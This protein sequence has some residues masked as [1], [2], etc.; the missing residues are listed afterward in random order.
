MSRRILL[1][2][3]G[4][5]PVGTGREVLLASR[6]LL[7]VGDDLHVAAITQPG[8]VATE[9][10]AGGGTLHALSHR[11][12][13]D[14]ASIAALAQTIRRVRPRLVVSWGWSAWWVTGAA[15]AVQ[16]GRRA[17]RWLGSVGRPTTPATPIA[18]WAARRLMR[19][20]D[21]L[22]AA[23]EGTSNACRVLGAQASRVRLCPPGVAE[24]VPAQLS[25]EAIAARLGLPLTTTWTLTVAPLVAHSKLSR[26]VWAADQLDV[27]LQGLTHVLVGA[28]PLASQF[29]RRAR[30]QQA[31]SRIHMLPACPEI[32]ELLAHVRLVWQPGE[33]AYGGILVDALA[34]GVPAVAVASDTTTSIIESSVTGQLVP[35]DPPSELPRRALPLLEDDDLHCRFA[36]ASRLRA[37]ESFPHGTTWLLQRTAISD[38]IG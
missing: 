34:A 11:P 23:T 33:A 10:A 18:R 9:V 19:R 16:S 8:S 35:A 21:L 24:A 7:E 25:R 14:A 17:P 12:R 13:P 36:D 31:A 15:M 22:L 20:C 4:L 29:A 27:V 1:V 6:R 38:L 32:H 30:A 26:L 28:G 37:R 5:D 2:T 3:R